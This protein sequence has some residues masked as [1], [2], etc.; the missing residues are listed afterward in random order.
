MLP[1]LALVSGFW[2]GRREPARLF[3]AAAITFWTLV[4]LWTARPER[5]RI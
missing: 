2:F 4:V 5:V 1:V 3:G